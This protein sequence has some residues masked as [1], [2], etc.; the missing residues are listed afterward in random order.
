MGQGRKSL[1]RKAGRR[2]AAVPFR[3]GE[4]KLKSQSQS[5]SRPVRASPDKSQNAENT[6]LARELKE[7]QAQQSA[8]SDVLAVINSS[9]GNLGRVFEAIVEKALKI[10]DA[11]FG[12]LW[13]VDGELARPVATR[14]VPKAYS[15]FLKQQSLPLTE[16]FGSGIEDKPFNHV[17]DL[18]ATESYRRRLPLTVGSV[19]LG[20]I[21]SYLAVP[22]RDNGA[23]AGVLG[24]YR[25]RVQPFSSRQIALLQGFAMQAEIAMK[26]AR[27]LKATQDGLERQTAT[28]DILKVIAGSPSNVQPVFE[29]MLDKAISLCAAKFGT[30]FLYDGKGFTLAADRNLP[31]DYVK[32]VHGRSFSPEANAG[33]RFLVEKK[34]TLHVADIFADAAYA[35]GE[36][37]RKFA[38]ELG[39]VRSLVAT[40]LLRNG[41]LI[42]NF[43]I[44]RKDPGGFAE[45][46]IALLENFANQAVIAI[47][48]ARLFNETREALEQQTA[49]A[50][51][52]RIIS[53]SPRDL[54]PVFEAMLG[55]A[56]RICDAKF[57][58]ILLYDGE[59]FHATHLHDVPRSYRAFWDKHGPIAPKPNTGLGRLAH[60]KQVIHIPDLKLD[61]AYAAREPLRIATV[62]EA[63][64]RSF[65]AV[66]M[67][68]ES[69]FIG[70]IVI[71]RQEVRPFTEKQIELVKNFAD[72]AVIAIENARLFKEVQAKTSD[73]EES[74]E[75]QTATAEVLRVI[76][77]SAFD[78]QTVLATL[79]DSAARLCDADSSHIYLVEGDVAKL[80][81]CSG[82]SKEYE[83]LLR[84]NPLKPDRGTLVGRTLQEGVVVHLPDAVADK[85]YRWREAQKLGRFRTM[86]GIPMLRNGVT[87]GVMA[88][89]RSQVRPFTDKQ[90]ELVQTFADQAV[91]AI[92]N[93]RLL[94][95]LRKR[96]DDLS[97]SLQHQTATSQILGVISSSKADIQPVFDAI[98][99]SAA[100][101]FEP[102][103][104]TITTLNDDGRLHWNASAATL[105]D[106]DIERAKR[107]Y[108]IPFD[109]ERA[110]SARALLQRRIIEIPDVTAPDTPEFTRKA[111]A[112][113]G[114]GSVTF[115]PLIKDDKGIGTI[116]LT[117]LQA[118]FKLS[119]KQ[120]ALVRT[121][122]DQA[123][124]AIENARLFDEVQAKTSDLEES[125]QQ[126]TATADVLKV[127][128]R[129]AFDLDAVLGTLV[130][131]AARLCEAE[132]G[133][134][135]LR[136]G[137]ECHV[138]NVYG[139]SPQLEAF[140]RTHPIPIDAASSTA[141]A[142]ASG[143]AVQTVDL[144]ADPALGEVARQYQKLGGHRTNLGVPLKRNGETIG[145]FTLTRQV[146]RAFTDKQ[147]ELVQ[148]FA[149]QAVIAI[150]NARLFEEVQAK[151]RDLEQSL[152]QQTATAEILQVISNSPG[153]L[154][155]VFRAVLENATRL[156][157]ARFGTL[158]RF[159][160][161]AFYFAADIGTPP[162]LADYVRRPGPFQGPPGGM[163][164]RIHRTKQFQHSHD[165]AAEANPGLAATLGGA[166]STLGVPILKDDALVG[167]IVIYRQ[168]VRPF[169]E[170]EIALV[171]SFGS[172][173]AIAI[174]NARLFNETKEALERQT[175]TAEILQV[176]ASSPSDVQPVFD[177][178]ATRANSL[179]GGFSSTVFLFVDGVAHLRAFTPT[180]PEADEVLKSTFPRPVAEFTPFQMAQAGKVT[181]ISDTEALTNEIKNV[182]RARGYRSMLFAPL[183]NRDVSIGFIAVTR[184]QPGNFA[185]HH[186]QLLRTFADQAVIAIENAR[187]FDE[188]QAKTRDLEESLQQQTATADVLKVISRSAFDLQT[189]LDTLVESAT[190]L[191]DAQD[192]LIFLPS[193]GF[194]RAVARYGF[195][196]EYH[197]YI[198]SNPIQIDRGSVV[199]RTVIDKQLVHI[200][201][202]LTDPDYTRFDAQ[203]I[204]GYRAVLGAPLLREGNVV[205]VIFLTR[206]RPEPFTEKQ[207]ELVK[208][209]ADQAIIAIE[210]SRLFDEVQ[211]KT[212]DLT[213]SLQQQTATAE[214]LKVISR[215][216]FDLQTVLDTL[217][218]S[219]VTLSGARWG[220]IFQKRGDRY[221]LTAEYGYTPEMLEYGR[222]HPIAAGMDTNVGRTALSGSVVQI[223]DVL[224]DPDYKAFG[225]QRV[226]HFRAM[227]G[228]PIMR[229]GAVEGVFS[230]ARPEPGLFAPRQVELVQTFADQALIAIENARLFDEVQAKTS[231]LE[232]SLRQ[233]TA[234]ADVLKT[235]SRSTFD[236]P[237]V[238][239]AL[240]ETAAQ[241]CD[242]DKG[243]IT[244]Q[245][246]GA[247]YRAES[248][249]FSED[250]M[251]YVRDVPVAVDRYTATG[252]ALLEGVV[253]HIPDV[254]ADPDYNF[255][256]GQRLGD[257]RALLGVPMLRGGVPIG[258]ITLTRTEPRAFSEKQIELATTFADQA[259]IAIQNVRLFDEVQAKTRD[260]EESL[261]QQ[262]ATADVLKVINRSAF[263]LEAVFNAV[264]KSAMEL[265]SAETAGLFLREGDVLCVRG[266]WGMDDEF[267]KLLRDNPVQ[268]NME[269]HMGRAVLT[270]RVANIADFAHSD[271]KLRKFHDFRPFNSF[272][273]VP[274]M[275]DGQAV[276]VFTINRG[277]AGGFTDRE[278]ELV[279]TFADQAAIA[280]ENARL[281]DEVQAKTRELSKSLD[282]LRAAQDRLIQTEKL[283][284]LG[285][286]TAGIAHEIKNPLNFVNNFSALSAELVDEMDGV[287]DEA[288][289]GDEKRGELDEIRKL[290]KSN[291]EKV[292]QHGK[293]ADSIV[294]NMLLHSRAGSGERRPVEINAIIDESL[295]LAYHGARAEKQG[296]NITLERE[297]D[298][299]AGIAD[300]YPQEIT[301]VLLNLVSNGFY[302]ATKRAAEVGNGFEPKLRAASKSLGDM[303]EI[304]IRD[305]GAGIPSEIREKIF[306]PFFTTKPAG[307]GTGLGLSMSHDIVVKQHG[308][309]IDIATEQGTFTEFIIT[310]PRT[311][312]AQ[313]GAGE[314]KN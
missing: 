7:A 96:T 206:T 273:A 135:F 299:S 49:T 98:V 292:V 205:G 176:I 289:L 250:F 274:L 129:S 1:G 301:R 27:L 209:F 307:E 32:A 268:I 144:L 2:K 61:P 43:S 255:G 72:Q 173:A 76:S 157:D 198:G 156:C 213:E 134:L 232:E 230:L 100:R 139:F 197:Q 171:R 113:G 244:R 124:I 314:Q 125:L 306:N 11:G 40:P 207:I 146:V 211:A 254:Q 111:A 303:V 38:V 166:R 65:L 28:S 8:S 178:I 312:P 195:T 182:A 224:A 30:L 133:I 257:Y 271:T 298:P 248:C 143:L 4:A 239:H 77:R 218:E 10:C 16:A 199:G 241:L 275:R 60:T 235:I 58:H 220:T 36:A 261:R 131:S 75:Q 67:L 288:R 89:T 104:A 17:A 73:L 181:Q 22:L 313:A 277:E 286:L 276:G 231:D 216:A 20:G 145:V 309:T 194:Y 24:V 251:N 109:P 82:F 85:E 18:A 155:P 305:N 304:R 19:E 21:R 240:V 118:G 46:Q 253:V 234:T 54:K 35:R 69:G 282:D 167:A 229:E 283:A 242:A 86:L 215:S 266:V 252:R 233:Q 29:A 279:K 37:L 290:L 177:A 127:I 270:G 158:F 184:V 3:R 114:F 246:D 150:E 97:E 128:S 188:V 147:I 93:S 31:R 193:D 186:V 90:I 201:D 172:Q 187:L 264:S 74:L 119:E 55:N 25:K 141:R 227:L 310:L 208:T 214:V 256:Q 68:K 200:S 108:P 236:L 116:I 14:N 203:T 115:V 138:A 221:H 269:S 180:T 103:A 142:A 280:V 53:S 12:G 263:D 272:L 137:N 284:S 161:N 136:K 222:A 249:G 132:R 217:V 51:V 110:P 210:N 81:V 42:G 130:E 34:S 23:L 191:C 296:F 78:V 151:T 204:A 102:C 47:E 123:V 41:E 228:I 185:E 154:G 79:T 163:V 71:Y 293:R 281:F 265:C 170:R 148:T 112:A 52:L 212:R 285:Q 149:D 84:R 260:L 50:E 294:K 106:F 190:R 219:A 121:F 179:I 245:K 267:T 59:R 189:V 9:P 62:D 300:I 88:V 243:T 80:A 126:Q 66:P 162:A 202:V 165:Y 258:V 101:L 39:G 122:A 183:M 95:E 83:E 105:P 44:Y 63:G 5:K 238:L 169:S 259:A 287:L 196:P 120:L 87:V 26:N 94:N 302:A 159:E 164:N 152:Q 64:A 6:R 99:G 160:G 117:H 237:A 297:F 107:I 91:I 33:F 225:Y 278:V 295:N 92:E 153:Q 140:A 247:F 223:P 311:A 308:G 174:E 226:G 56:M 291:L 15:Q 45:N 70:A 262:T 192:A 48:N 175:A 57:G 13:I 168:E